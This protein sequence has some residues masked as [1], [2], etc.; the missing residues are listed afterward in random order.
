[1]R[2]ERR[3][4]GAEPGR[5][6]GRAGRRRRGRSLGSAPTCPGVPVPEACSTE[7]TQRRWVCPRSTEG[8]G[9]SQGCPWGCLGRAS[10]R[11]SRCQL[12]GRH[13][14]GGMGWG[15]SPPSAARRRCRQ[16][17]REDGTWL[18]PGQ[19]AAPGSPPGRT[20]LMGPWARTAGHFPLRTG[21]HSGEVAGASSPPWDTSEPS[22]GYSRLGRAR[23]RRGRAEPIASETGEGASQGAQSRETAAG[24]NPSPQLP[25]PAAGAG[26]ATLRL[27]AQRLLRGGAPTAPAAGSGKMVEPGPALLPAKAEHPRGPGDPRRRPR[28]PPGRGRRSPRRSVTPAGAAM[29]CQRVPRGFGVTGADW[30]GGRGGT[31]EPEPPPRLQVVAENPPGTRGSSFWG[32]GAVWGQRGLGAVC[33]GSG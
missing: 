5:R 14:R 33:G 23:P 28:P 22:A 13:H 9:W 30:G 11:G 24:G 2:R 10:P 21:G 32:H 15:P 3:A 12:S 31:G 29:S 16:G 26:T 1:M 25:S 17:T 18:S 6:A 20:E 4:G 8:S 7:G 27:C 19:T